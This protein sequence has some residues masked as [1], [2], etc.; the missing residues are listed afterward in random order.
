[1]EEIWSIDL[2]NFPKFL[3]AAL[4]KYSSK[5]L[6]PERRDFGADPLLAP[7]PEANHPD[8]PLKDIGIRGDIGD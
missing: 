2:R 7:P 8:T 4:K 3:P 1:M 6:R 5:N